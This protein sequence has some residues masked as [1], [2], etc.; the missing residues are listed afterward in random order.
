MPLLG[1]PSLTGISSFL[2]YRQKIHLCGALLRRR[3]GAKKT[4]RLRLVWGVSLSAESDQRLCLW[5][6]RAPAALDRL[7]PLR[8]FFLRF[9]RVFMNYGYY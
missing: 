7:L 8:G 2:A 9:F 1:N 4:K 3:C 6:P 5:K